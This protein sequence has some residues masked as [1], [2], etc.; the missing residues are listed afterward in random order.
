MPNEW[1]EQLEIRDVVGDAGQGGY[2]ASLSFYN[3]HADA[4]N[5]RLIDLY[6]HN[7]SGSTWEGDDRIAMQGVIVPSTVTWNRAASTVDAMAYSY[8]KILDSLPVTGC[9]FTDDAAGSAHDLG[10]GATLAD[11]IQHLCDYHI[12]ITFGF[13]TTQID[14]AG[15]S[16]PYGNAYA[17]P[18]NAS[19]WQAMK[20]IASDEFYA[21]YWDRRNRLV[22][23]RHPQFEGALPASVATLDEDNLL[24][25]VRA[26]YRRD[27]IPKN[28][29]LLGLTSAMQT[30]SSTYPA[31]VGVDLRGPQYEVRCESQARLNTL[32]ERAYK[33][34][35]REWTIYVLLG[36]TWDFELLDRVQVTYSGTSINGVQFSWSAK[37]FW[38][39]RV[40]YRKQ[41]VFGWTTE[42]MLDEGYTQTGYWY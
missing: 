41:Q 7:F 3:S 38:V 10:A 6:H 35:V 28:V 26:E 14:V 39:S 19:L 30:L 22:Y 25:P 15:D 32:A 8:H 31:G 11:V 1:L 23:R 4:P 13:D 37:D 21:I 9:W 2:M 27:R 36:G 5:Y 20:K 17:V 29:T 40:T 34:E 24:A 18:E 16:T 42:L 33:W 12:T